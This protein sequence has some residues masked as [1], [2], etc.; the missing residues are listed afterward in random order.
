MALNLGEAGPA[1]RVPVAGKV[2][3][4]ESTNIETIENAASY[5]IDAMQFW[6]QSGAVSRR[7]RK[8]RASTRYQNGASSH[9]PRAQ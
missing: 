6:I 5:S 4:N 7:R 2:C 9:R 3:C 8:K 1:N